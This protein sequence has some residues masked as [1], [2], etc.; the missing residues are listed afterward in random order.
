MKQISK[1]HNLEL[2]EGVYCGL[3]GPCYETLAEIN[4][5]RI[6]GGDAVGK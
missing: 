1:D 2:R 6:V 3:G 5:L 4:M